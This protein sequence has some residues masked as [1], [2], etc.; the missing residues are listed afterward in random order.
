MNKLSHKHVRAHWY[1]TLN[2]EA[3]IVFNYIYFTERVFKIVLRLRTCTLFY[4]GII[5]HKFIN[6]NDNLNNTK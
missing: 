4:N 1:I 2:N 3:R 5:L 6:S